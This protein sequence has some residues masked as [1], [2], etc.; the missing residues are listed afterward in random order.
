MLL[1]ILHLNFENNP[2]NSI[3]L[4]YG[5]N[6]HLNSLLLRNKKD[7]VLSFALTA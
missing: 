6:F 4:C 7:S 3:A 2:P 5:E 1:I